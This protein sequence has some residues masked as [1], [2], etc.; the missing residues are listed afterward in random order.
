MDEFNLT[1]D[2]IIQD[3]PRDHQPIPA[4]LLLYYLNSFQGQF[5]FFL[6]Q[7]KPTDLMDAKAKAKSLNDNWVLAGKP[8]ILTPPRAR[9]NLSQEPCIM[10]SQPLILELP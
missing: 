6:N 10:L 7:A 2:N 1:F 3:I 9:E 4:T 5:R 8:D